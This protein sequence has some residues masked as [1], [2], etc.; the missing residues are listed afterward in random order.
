[1]KFFTILGLVVSILF[2][3]ICNAQGNFILNGSFEEHL[4]QVC[5]ECNVYFN[6]YPS[7]VYHWDNGGWACTLCDKDYK[8]K[9]DEKKWEL[10][11]FD[12]IPPQDGNAMIEMVYNPGMNGIH[13]GATHLTARSTQTLQVGCL[14]EVSCWVYI[15]SVLK[16]DPDWARHIGIALLPQKIAF[17][18]LS[19]TREIPRI[20]IDTVIYNNWYQVKWRIRPL[21]KS[22]YLMIG[23]FRDDSWPISQ[24]YKEARYYIDN[25][26]MTEI[27]SKS[28]IRDSSIYYCSKYDPQ[29]NPDL[30]PR[31]DNIILYFEKNSYMMTPIQKAVLDR[32]CVFAR[33]YPNEVFEISGHT[34]SIGSGN[35]T[36][37]K[38][39]TQSV[40]QYLRD[41]LKLPDYRFISL[42][43]GSK[44][45]IK[46]NA[47]E[48][49]RTLNRRVEIRQSELD[50]P[51]VFYRR[52]LQATKEQRYPEA[53]SYLNKWVLKK[54]QGEATI[55]LFDPRFEPLKKDKRWGVLEKKIRDS[56]RKLK[57]SKYA[58]F[59]DS[60]RLEDRKNLGE[61][62]DV[63]NSCS[64]T[65]PELDT[66]PFYLPPVSQIQI[67]KKYREHFSA[68]RPIFEEVGFPKR[69]EFGE[70]AVGS[71][72]MLL[73]HSIDS[74]TYVKYLPILKKTCEEGEAPWLAYA[75]LYDR[76]Q[77]VADKPQRYITHFTVL[78]NGAVRVFPWEGDEDTAN[79]YRAKLGLPLVPEKIAKAMQK[80]E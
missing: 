48:T 51:M 23:V 43:M 5:L 31:M 75:R 39:R 1:M 3:Q 46:S 66:V 45:P 63:L 60:L 24:S 9:S 35:I 12:R 71:A 21:C 80:K 22:N 38:N 70:S 62:S 19:G 33:K 44:Q 72:F 68:L 17:N 78:D 77:M 40:L 57:Y 56:Y 37:A 50:L 64:G 28:A 8:Q 32:F 16:A 79:E 29:T 7:L 59:I 55:L 26:S 42:S 15:D 34:D 20:N 49:G 47:T 76:C 10:C 58:F 30:K 11:P 65:I 74:A 4:K 6:Q 14:Y 18:N 2:A 67:E 41:T 27:P 25:V 73:L 53:Y 52:A 36:L 54:E 13:G 69:S 61:L